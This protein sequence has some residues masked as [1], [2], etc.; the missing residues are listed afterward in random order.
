M[1]R[2]KYIIRSETLVLRIS[3]GKDRYY[4]RVSH[5]LLGNPNLKYWDATRERFGY[6]CSNYIEN[7][8]ILDQFKSI[9]RNLIT[10][11]PALS[12]HQI[13]SFYKRHGNPLS[14]VKDGINT[15]ITSVE[16]YIKVII[17]REKSKPG[18]NYTFYYKL[19]QKCRKV[20]P[21]FSNMSFQSIDFDSCLKI[22]KIFAKHKNYTGISKGFRAL[23]GKAD[24]DNNVDFSLNQIGGFKFQDYNPNKYNEGIGIPEVL[25]KKKLKE[26]LNFE[27]DKLTPSYKDR[28]QVNLF[29]DFCRFMFYTFLA[30]CDA[31]RLEYLNISKRNT[32]ILRRRKTCKLVEIPIHPEVAEIIS[33]YRSKAKGNYIFPILSRISIRDY[34]TRNYIYIRFRERL[35]IWLK[36]VGDQLDLDFNLHSYIFRHTAITTALNGG[37]SLSYVAQLTGTT[38]ENIQRYYYNGNTYDN[39]TLF[40]R[41][42]SD[43]VGV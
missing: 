28:Y 29:F 24:V 10:E 5:L 41:I 42:F 12:A 19:L 43:V 11:Y 39:Q 26:F 16:E 40:I 20:I 3:E 21:D 25:N 22:A 4:K 34:K 27:I 38:P 32:L 1:I 14:G 31:I 13:A 9:Y 7:N 17:E 23:L 30:P 6:R 15:H 8:E 33:K 37:L 35:N 2:L 36:A 18:D